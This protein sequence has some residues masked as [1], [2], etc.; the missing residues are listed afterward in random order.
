MNALPTK[1]IRVCV[2]VGLWLLTTPAV[3]AQNDG[4]ENLTNAALEAAAAIV[5]NVLAQASDSILTNEVASNSVAQSEL[6]AEGTNALTDTN[7]PAPANANVQP[8]PLE[9]RRQWLLRQRAGTLDTNEPGKPRNALRTN[10][11]PDSIYRPI[12][13]EYATFKLITERNIFDP[14]R[15]PRGRGG[16][17]P[18]AK[19]I[20]SFALVGVMTYEKGT[21]AFFDGNA[22]EY[23]K[24]VKLADTIAGYKI[25]NIEPNTIRMVSGT[26]QVELHVGMQ[27]RRE[28]GGGWAPSAQAE[29]YVADSPAATHTDSTSAGAGSDVLERLRKR[30]ESE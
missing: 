3:H 7:P 21:F 8:G 20:D 27:M 26:N 6:S 13:P 10:T 2:A 16:P 4:S 18:K 30:R 14:N 17:P 11:V 9:S 5:S 25:T 29:T 19:T 23:K 28:E 12:K 15:A 24:A 22:A 1:T